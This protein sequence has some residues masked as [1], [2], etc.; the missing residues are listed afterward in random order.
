MWAF[1]VPERNVYPMIFFAFLIGMVAGLR[2]LA[3]AAVISWAAHLG[4]LH[5][6]GS[7]VSF[8]GHPLT[9]WIVT[10]LAVLELV[11]DKLP[12]TPSRTAS[13]GFGARIAM[14]ALCGAALGSA[15]QFLVAG[16]FAGAIGAIAG[17]LGGAEGRARLA[18]A[19]GKDLPAALVEDICAIGGAILIA[20]RFA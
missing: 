7:W 4:W 14:G 10:A 9:L 20:A 3:P 17:T 5:L 1:F 18:K 13:M 15:G 11:I 16:L 8:L 12:A 19:I 2:A 6:E